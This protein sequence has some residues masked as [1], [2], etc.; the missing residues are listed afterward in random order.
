M[1]TFRRRQ[2]AAGLLLALLFA[3]CAPAFPG[4]RPGMDF[5][6][7]TREEILSVEAGDLYT[8]VER[9][10]PRW[11]MTRG[12][13]SF[14]MSNDVLVYQNQ[15]R[16]GTADMLRQLSPTSVYRL[17]Y[18]DGVTAANTLPGIGSGHVEGAIILHTHAREDRES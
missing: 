15:A 16:L 4:S 13:R 7:L 11:L 18:L 1:Y 10:R 8:V 3:A 17:E 9:L 12:Q 6:R 2:P 14:A 5:N